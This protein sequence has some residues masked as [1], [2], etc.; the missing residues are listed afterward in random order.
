VG[1]G[2]SGL[3]CAV[4]LS[5][6]GYNVTVLESARQLGGRAR[7]VAFNEYP[8]DNGQ[9]VLIG[10]YR[11]TLSLFKILDIP[12]NEHL[13][14][15]NLDLHIL[16]KGGSKFNLHL[17]ALITPLNLF[18][19]LITAKG[20]TLKDKWRALRFGFKLFANA[21]ITGDSDGND[22]SVAELLKKEK[23]TPN[24]IKALW[25]PICLASLNTH[26]DEASAGIFIRVIHDTFCRSS[27]DAD[28]IL[29]S[30][31]L[32]SLF[33]DPALDYIEQHGGNIHL[34][35]RVT[36]LIIEQRHIAGVI[37]DKD[38]YLADHVIL[39]IPPNACVP[40]LK[41]HP[42]LH[43][44]AYNLSGF[45]FNPI[46]TVYLKYPRS[47]KTDQPVQALTGTTSQWVIDRRVVGQPGIIAVVISGPGPHM[48]KD[49]NE[50]LGHVEAE[51]AD[52]FPHW[53]KPDGAKIIREKRATFSCRAGINSLRPDNKT[54]VNGLWLA[55]DYTRTPYPAT[56]ESA[57]ISGH[58]T[59]MLINQ[60]QLESVQP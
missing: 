16:D 4:E 29:P 30:V 44:I 3:S 52:C 41:Q 46:V 39:A 10:A 17:P 23:Q 8:V 56:L 31:D 19:G 22:M 26:I 48:E 40:L 49:N 5:R 11:Q 43:D 6:I 59:A 32:G 35:K 13:I 14:R 57:V 9:H 54:N 21:V 7:R 42:A 18:F 37:C 15:Q 51:L 58:Q 2:W 20:F 60:F 53:P 1:G 45:D 25:E 33:P 55:G 38:R 47:V 50:L 28:L 34:S 36:E 12:F 27:N 24:L